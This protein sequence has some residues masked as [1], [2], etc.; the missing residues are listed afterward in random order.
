MEIERKSGKIHF[1]GVL[2]LIC[3]M[4]LEKLGYQTPFSHYAI[5]Q[6]IEKIPFNPINFTPEGFETAQY[7][8]VVISVENVETNN[9]FSQY[10]YDQKVH[11]FPYDYFAINLNI[12]FE[13][14]YSCLSV[15]DPGG[16]SCS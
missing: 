3:W 15:P 5:P 4:N 13:V 14:N 16:E 6:L 11:C 1:N 9:V 10:N 2:K 8:R 12:Q 7:Q